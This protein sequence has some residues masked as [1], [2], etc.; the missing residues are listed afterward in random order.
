ML[1]FRQ[2]VQECFA[3]RELVKEFDRLTGSNLSLKGSG[4]DLQ[5][6]FGS[7]RFDGE[8]ERFVEFV[9]E[10]VWARL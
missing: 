3:N 9:R 10:C 2:C 1:D 8:A 5:I 4:L 7:G 6:D